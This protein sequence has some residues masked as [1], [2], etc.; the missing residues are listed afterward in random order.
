MKKSLF[1]TSLVCL[2]SSASGVAIGEAIGIQED[3]N[4]LCDALN[5]IIKSD[6]LAYPLNIQLMDRSFERCISTSSVTVFMNLVTNETRLMSKST[7]AIVETKADV[8]ENL[9][10]LMNYNHNHLIVVRRYSSGDLDKFV[11]R[12]WKSLLINVSFLL[13][14]STNTSL[15]TFIP[16]NA[17]N[18]NDTMLRAINL[19]DVHTRAWQ[20]NNFFPRKLKNF[21]G[22]VIRVTTH[23]NVIPYI[24]RDE[25]DVNG[26]RVLKGRVIQIIDSLSYSLNFTVNFDYEASVAGYDNSYRKVENNEAD[27]FI[28]NV[29]IDNNLIDTLDFSLPVFFEYMKFVVPPGKRYT[30]V[31]NF[32]RVFKPIAWILIVIVFLL[33]GGTVLA[34]SFRSKKIR[35]V[36]FGT[37]YH[38][39]FMD[40]IATIFG[41]S[42]ST[43]P[44]AILPRFLIVNFVLFCFVIRSIYQGSLYNFLQSGA[45]ANEVQ[46]IDEMVSKGFT[47]FMLKGYAKYMDLSSQNYASKKVVTLSEFDEILD[48]IADTNFKG[49]LMHTASLIEYKNSL[50]NRKQSIFCKQYL[51][52]IAMVSYLRKNFYFTEVVNEKIGLFYAAGL[53]DFWDRRSKTAVVRPAKV[54]DNQE[55]ITLKNLEEKTM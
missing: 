7:V 44:S 19:F 36:A 43:S 40:Y 37:R 9:P 34:I 6:L 45:K 24:V 16:Y 54:H 18:C 15:Q 41:S 12:L 1:Y 52:T 51:M 13:S 33:V 23:R 10:S 28:G 17:V 4:Y 53:I 27:M 22:C 11:Y 42:L 47:F 31:E 26:E 49:S 21:H 35:T 5:T 29:A 48:K 20:T 25:S 14:T 30:Q 55:P 32:G 2:V 3:S 46:S 50:E 8:L 39:A 38:N